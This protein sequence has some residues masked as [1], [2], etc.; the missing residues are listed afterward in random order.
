MIPEYNTNNIYKKII[1]NKFS[2]LNRSLINSSIKNMYEEKYKELEKKNKIYENKINSL[3]ETMK[4][5]RV[6]IKDLTDLIEQ[7]VKKNNTQIEKLNNN[8]TDINLL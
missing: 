1:D 3:E 5:S 7:F 8:I 6:T 4:S 2:E